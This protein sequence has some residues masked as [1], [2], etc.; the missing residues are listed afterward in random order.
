MTVLLHLLDSREVNVLAH[1]QG[2]AVSLAQALA[3]GLSTAD[4][5]ARVLLGDWVEHHP[6]VYVSGMHPLT[7]EARAQAALLAIGGDCALA[8][9]SAA[10]VWRLPDCLPPEMP[11]LVVPG[12]RRYENL[13][14]VQVKR[15]RPS[16]YRTFVRDGF[17]VTP[18]E[19]TV[20]DLA[21]EMPPG[22]LRSLVEALLLARRTTV[23]R[24]RDTLRRGVAGSAKLRRLLGELDPAAHSRWELMLYTAL[25]AA[26][27]RPQRQVRLVAPGGR[28]CYLDLAFEDIHL[29]IEVDG[30]LPHMRR[31]AE[32]RRRGNDVCLELGWELGRFAVQELAEDMDRVVADVVRWVAVRR[33]DLGR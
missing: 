7:P 23:D 13:T 10:W 1:E 22:E 24:L 14:R 11:Q 33:A 12:D 32:D 6:R 15:V 26:G 18:L 9:R 17:Q 4:V 27:L 8:R 31:F 28:R 19:A 29:G 3:A 25:R 20:R 16:L 30:F 21:H 5:T 2:G